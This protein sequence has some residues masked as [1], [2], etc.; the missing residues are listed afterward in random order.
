MTEEGTQAARPSIASRW[1]SRLDAGSLLYGTIVSAAALA[2]GAGRGETA[3][4]MDEA[5]VTGVILAAML[6]Y[7]HVH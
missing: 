3:L 1:L 6:F 7:L 2:V 4:G 5:M